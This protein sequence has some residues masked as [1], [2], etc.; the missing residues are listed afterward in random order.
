MTARP[1]SSLE[2]LLGRPA[3]SPPR[4]S[5]S[6]Y[7]ALA[8]TIELAAALLSIIRLFSSVG[9]GGLH[10]LFQYLIRTPEMSQAVM[11]P[12]TRILKLVWKTVEGFIDD[13]QKTPTLWYS[14]AD[15]QAE[16]ATRLSRRLEKRG[17]GQLEA[18][19]PEYERKGLPHRQ[20]W[21]RVSCCAP[22]RHGGTKRKPHRFLPDI[23]VSKDPPNPNS[24]PDRNG[25]ANWPAIWVCEIKSNSV[26]SIASDRAKVRRM[27]DG[28][29]ADAGMCM[30]LMLCRARVDLRP[31]WQE[32]GSRRY[33]EYR[34]R[35]PG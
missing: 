13:W 9:A 34:G 33:R 2:S 35:L 8:D 14:E 29:V 5:R 3:R 4:L 30:E 24:P 6:S 18:N 28:G 1:P 17:L 7:P 15:V 10:R 23:A 32:T 26:Q 25:V 19:Y 22:V 16:L 20:Y 21:S 31:G 12:N 11:S 27:I